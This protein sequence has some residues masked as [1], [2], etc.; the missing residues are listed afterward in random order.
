M[1]SLSL[2]VYLN[3]AETELSGTSASTPVVA[4]MVSQFNEARAAE[5]MPPMGFLTPFLYA[6]AA[7]NPAAFTDVTDGDIGCFSG[8][9][10][11]ARCCEHTFSAAEGWD[12]A[13]G[14][15]SP[16]YQQLLAS[17]LEAGKKTRRRDRRLSASATKLN[18]LNP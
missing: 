13:S 2:L 9:T 15:G 16:N 3:G 7:S 12:A 8:G 1:R 14:L 18:T 4:A 17:A 5:G 10:T 6:T 11:T